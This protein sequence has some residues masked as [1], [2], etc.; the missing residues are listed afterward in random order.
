VKIQAS[1]QSLNEEKERLLNAFVES[2]YV[3]FFVLKGLAG[4]SKLLVN[5]I[6]TLPIIREIKQKQI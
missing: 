4:E 2:E 5:F 3:P 6:I 1:I